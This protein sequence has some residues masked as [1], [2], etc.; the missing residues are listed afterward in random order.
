MGCLLS[1][2]ACEATSCLCR[3]A[4]KCCGKAVPMKWVAGRVAYTIIFFIFSFIAWLF[5][6]Y[7]EKIL[8]WVPVLKDVCVE[9][10]CY[11]ALS[12]FRVSFALALFH[13]ILAM[14]MIGA[15]RKGDCR[16]HLQDGFWG[17]KVLLL[18]GMVVGAFFIPNPV[19]E[20]YGWVALVA[21]GL[22]IV[23]QLIL[24][25]DFAHSWA[26]N[27][28]AK[29]E[30]SEVDDRRWFWAMFGATGVMLCAAVGLTI[31]MYTLFHECTSNIMFVTVNLI[32]CAVICFLSLH[33][34]VQ[35]ANPMS[36][37]LQPALISVY[38]TYL[39][40]SAI[41]SATDECNPWK[42]KQ[43]VNDTALVL[44][45]VFTICAVCYATFRASSTIGATE[46]EKESLMAEQETDEEA[47]RQ[48]EKDHDEEH[49]DEPLPYNYFRYHIVYALGAMYIA[50][51]MTDWQTVSGS[52][53]IAP[54]VDSGEAA[55]WVKIAS[56]W[57]CFGMYLWT[58]LAPVLFPDREW[59]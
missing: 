8:K 41:Q 54:T 34:R 12:V 50:M 24:L 29:L 17:L 33:P 15:S 19:F 16:V 10:E 31:A 44:G 14:M 3:G 52:K 46:P 43:S 59:K 23:I 40:F 35:E 27:W 39:V 2:I 36:G 26:E 13:L 18:I 9:R 51:L 20:Y 53:D 21:S 58:L 5:R 47:N 38:A 30:S 4:C 25:V 22:F 42:Q 45:A 57:V 6:S 48:E 28:V 1:C 37:L 56:G 7:A 55:V 11:G 49:H 32:A